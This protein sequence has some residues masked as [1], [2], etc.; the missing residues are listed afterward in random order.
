MAVTTLFHTKQQLSQPTA[1]TSLML[2]A[3]KMYPRESV[4]FIGTMH[5]ISAVAELLVQTVNK[6]KYLYKD[7]NSM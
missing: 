7:Q 4:V 1:A 2:S 5:S 6:V 3:T